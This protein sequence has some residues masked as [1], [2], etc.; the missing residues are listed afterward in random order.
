MCEM[1]LSRLSVDQACKIF[2]LQHFA[3]ILHCDSANTDCRM[4]LC[5]QLWML[6]WPLL[7]YC[8]L[9]CN[10]VQTNSQQ[11]QQ[12]FTQ[13]SLS[14]LQISLLFYARPFSDKPVQIYID[15]PSPRFFKPFKASIFFLHYLTMCPFIQTT[16]N[17]GLKYLYFKPKGLI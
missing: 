4:P 13:I 12:T 5:C 3:R 14:V 8:R 2:F 10:A 17:L 9:V 7:I 1:L 6:T 11:L 16:C 15:F